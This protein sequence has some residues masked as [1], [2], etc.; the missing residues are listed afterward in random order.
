MLSGAGGA[1]TFVVLGEVSDPA[2]GEFPG[3]FLGE[4]LGEV[5]GEVP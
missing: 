2:P 5:P 4:V 3:E 1:E